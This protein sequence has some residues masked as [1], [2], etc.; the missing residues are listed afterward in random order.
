MAALTLPLVELLA[1]KEVLHI[2]TDY[3]CVLRKTL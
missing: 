2:K 3:L 1:L